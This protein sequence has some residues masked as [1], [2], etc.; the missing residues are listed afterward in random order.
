MRKMFDDRLNSKSWHEEVL[1]TDHTIEIQV[2]NQ[3]QNLA[4]EQMIF[5]SVKVW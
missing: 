1:A 5:M 3:L 2:R 4:G